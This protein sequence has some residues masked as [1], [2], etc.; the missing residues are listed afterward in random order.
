MRMASRQS[1]NSMKRIRK[2]YSYATEERTNICVEW[3]RKSIWPARR[4]WNPLVA[5]EVRP[6][7]KPRFDLGG[8][9]YRIT[10]VDQPQ[11]NSINVW[12]R[13]SASTGQDLVKGRTSHVQ[14]TVSVRQSPLFWA[15]SVEMRIRP[16]AVLLSKLS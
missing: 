16:L 5:R 12:I 6:R 8:Y 2:R 3:S 13:D 7:T 1:W 11:I 4:Y 14:S 15:H 9:L 10:G